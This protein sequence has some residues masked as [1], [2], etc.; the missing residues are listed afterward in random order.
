[1]VLRITPTP[2]RFPKNALH[3]SMDNTP[4]RSLPSVQQYPLQKKIVHGN[5]GSNHGWRGLTTSVCLFPHQ[6]TSNHRCNNS[7]YSDN[8]QY[9]N[10]NLGLFEALFIAFRVSEDPW[11][12]YPGY[13]NVT[14]STSIWNV[15]RRG[16]KC[17]DAFSDTLTQN[18]EVRL[19]AFMGCLL[20]WKKN[21]IFVNIGQ[22]LL[23]E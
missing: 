3:A 1:M 5:S 17:R 8:K 13:T 18:F 15:L 11:S 23:D 7:T 12:R 2:T 21:L 19:F 22:Y 14:G 6:I 10:H 16:Q 9:F 20:W 4:S